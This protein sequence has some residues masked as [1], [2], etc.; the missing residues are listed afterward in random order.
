MEKR[1][2][3]F[4]RRVVGK[5]V[6]KKSLDFALGGD[7]GN[8]VHPPEIADFLEFLAFQGIGESD[9]EGVHILFIANG[10]NAEPPREIGRELPDQLNV[11]REIGEINGFAAGFAGDEACDF[12]G[13]EEPPG[14]K[15]LADGLSVFPLKNGLQHVA[16]ESALLC[17]S[18]KKEDFKRRGLLNDSVFCQKGFKR[19]PRIDPVARK[20]RGEGGIGF[21]HKGKQ[22]QVRGDFFLVQLRLN[23]RGAFKKLLGA[24]RKGEREANVL[25]RAGAKQVLDIIAQFSDGNLMATKNFRGDT[26]VL[27]EDGE[28]KMLWLDG[29]VEQTSGLASRK[30]KNSLCFS[31]EGKGFLCGHHEQ[32]AAGTR[33]RWRCGTHKGVRASC[34]SAMQHEEGH[35]GKKKMHGSK[36]KHHSPAQWVGGCA[37]R[38]LPVRGIFVPGVWFGLDPGFVLYNVEKAR[39]NSRG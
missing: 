13:G 33:W 24:P 3:N 35:E 2:R 32:T 12:F 38:V 18:L 20:K 10:K 6:E 25:R 30:A 22:N 4:L 11:G 21:T 7:E 1:R 26:I 34:F 9:V 17:Q 14:D 27:T 16:V 5:K 19:V 8:N 28:Q 36:D 31:R 23:L 15:T 29:G 39:G 37:W